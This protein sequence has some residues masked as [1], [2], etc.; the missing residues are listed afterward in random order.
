MDIALNLLSIVIFCL[1][2]KQSVLNP[3]ELGTRCSSVVEC[4]LMMKLAVT[5]ISHDGLIE[6]LFVPF[7]AP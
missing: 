7:C 6:L 5:S 3:S 4:L 2:I 1:T